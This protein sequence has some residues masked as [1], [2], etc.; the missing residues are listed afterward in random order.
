MRGDE[1]TKVLHA[2][3]AARRCEVGWRGVLLLGAS[4]A[5]KSDLLLRLLA[6]GWRLVADDRVVAW[7]SG[8]RAFGRA[9]DVLHG[10]VELRGQGMA[11]SAALPF[12]EVACA[13]R[14]GAPAER[15]PAPAAFEVGG[16]SVPLHRI[17][18]FEA[19]APARL[20]RLLTP[21]GLAPPAA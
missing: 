10:Q 19:S 16:V 5:G 6:D 1:R 13:V 2:S 20:R 8:G 15:Q 14:L 18:P 12:A 9:P 7:R 17:A 11:R 3:L 4:G 21:V